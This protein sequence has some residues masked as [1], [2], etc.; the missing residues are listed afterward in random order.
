L[1]Y[2]LFDSVNIIVKKKFK[3]PEQILKQINECSS[4]GYVLFAFDNEGNPLVFSS[5]DSPK[6][7][8]AM[9]MQ[10]SNWSQ[11]IQAVNLEC[12][13]EQILKPDASE[14]DEEEV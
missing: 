9:Q 3:F 10:I 8:M 11:A 1:E 6:E 4:G 13:V 14:G 7:A 2:L 12:S 5:A